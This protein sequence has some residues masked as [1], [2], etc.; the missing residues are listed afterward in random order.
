METAANTSAHA[1]AVAFCFAKQGGHLCI[2]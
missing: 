1:G 2:I